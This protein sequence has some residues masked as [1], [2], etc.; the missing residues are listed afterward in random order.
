MGEVHLNGKADLHMHTNHS[1]G[2]YEPCDLLKKVREA[3]LRTISITDHDCVNGLDEA[4]HFGA[5]YDVIVIPG[6]ELSA[7]VNKKEIHLLGYFINHH[8]DN[9]LHSLS[10]LREERI[11]RAEKIVKKLNALNIPLKIESVLECA[12]H[13]AVG[14]P[15]I[16]AALVKGSFIR[17]YRDVFEKYIGD[18]CPAYEAKKESSPEK[19]IKLIAD[20]GGL[21]FL[22]HP[23]RAI[24]DATVLELLELGLDGIE[25][26]H[27]SHS[28]ASVKHYRSLVNE[29]YLLE[30]GGSDF[31]GGLKDDEAL[32]GNVTVS[33]SVIEKMRQ[34]L[35]SF[36]GGQ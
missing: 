9:L 2:A 13:G 4:I 10:T 33:S 5:M 6:I 26:V 14:R 36:N 29:H 31:H 15:H 25:V 1:D 17:S 35:F 27:P 16:A 20:S 18:G 3:G 7:S 11:Q 30:S 21:S 23:A 19:V 8:D 28:N 32:L 12:G 34:R 22:A 24:D